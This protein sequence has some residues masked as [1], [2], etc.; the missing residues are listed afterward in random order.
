[1]SVAGVAMAPDLGGA[2]DELVTARALHAVDAQ[3][4]TAD[5]D[6][7]LRCPG[8]CRVVL[9][10]HQSVAR[11]QGSGNRRS[12]VHVAEAEDQ[13]LRVEHHVVHLCHII[14]RVDAA[15]EL[16][17]PGT[18]WRISRG[19]PSPRYACHG[20]VTVSATLS[21]SHG[22]SERKSS[23][24]AHARRSGSISRRRVP[25]PSTLVACE[26]GERLRPTTGATGRRQAGW[27]ESAWWRYV[28][29]TT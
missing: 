3:V 7:V 11:I 14:E 24:C 28:P 16:D 29:E 22:A 12:Q 26:P 20:T 27:R 8:A 10:C 4:R 15:D 19:W 5:A 6:G 2:A 13:I 1:M 18:P 17:F 25:R 21:R 23:R 9:R